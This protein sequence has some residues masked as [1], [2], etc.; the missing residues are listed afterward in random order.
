MTTD[1]RRYDIDA[2]RFLVFSLLIVYH[3]AMLYLDGA[4]FHMKS[5]YLTETLNFPMVFINR[6]RMEI[7]FLISGVSCAMMAHTSRGAFLWRRIKRL[8]LPLLFG[9]LVVIPVQPYCEGVS[10]GLVE[11]GYGAFLLHYFGGYAWPAGAFTG[12]KTSFTWNHLWYLVYLLLYTIV[13]VALQPLLAKAR[14]LLTGLRGWR[15]LILP[16]LPALAATAFLKLRYP[17]THALVKDWYAHAIYFTMYL[18]GWW[19]GNDKGVWQELARL[20][21]H[22]LLLA[23]CAFAVYLGFDLVYS[24][25]LLTWASAGSWPMRNLYMWLAICAILGW[26]HTLLN[27][28]FAW[29]PWA[30]QAVFPWYILHQSAI[31][32]LAYWLVPLK[33]GPVLEPLLILAGTV[34][35]CWLG[36]SLLISKVNWLRPCFGL[37]A[38][39]R[40]A[41]VADTALS[42]H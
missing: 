17:E 14:P 11:P 37:P 22:A 25:N 9:V 40:Q 35:T 13:L 33:L 10:N 19:L 30:R 24:E 21:W 20:R 27:K 38:Q 8:L 32:L 41:V 16:A 28:P 29:L 7:V 18:Y 31:V 5:S 42:A 4:A 36:T 26:S 2:L 34:A 1:S 12:W 23:P 3:T 15:L 39:P 6:W